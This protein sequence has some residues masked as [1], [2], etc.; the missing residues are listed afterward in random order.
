V[1]Y[2]ASINIR[3][4]QGNRSMVIQCEELRQKIQTVVISVF[5]D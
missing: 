3:P 5:G 1:E 4:G 2:E